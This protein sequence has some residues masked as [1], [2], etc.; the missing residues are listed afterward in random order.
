M[1]GTMRAVTTTAAEIRSA[2]RQQLRDAL[3]DAVH[4][5]VVTVGWRRV[6]MGAVAAAVGVSRQTLHTEFGTKEALGQALVA[7]E[8]DRFLLGV[9]GALER[10]PGAL[11]PAVRTPP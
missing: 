9:T 2:A 7:R 5:L 8:T 1:S 11:G 10:H 3:L 6:R 4:S